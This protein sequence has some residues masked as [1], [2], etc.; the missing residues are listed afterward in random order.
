M[1]PAIFNLEDLRAR[2]PET[3][4]AL[5]TEHLSTLLAGAL[6]IGLSRPDAEEVVQDTFAAFLAGLDRFEGRSSVRTYLFGILY[7]KAS[8][9]RAKERREEGRD[10]IAAVVD[11]R[12]D[13]AGMWA[14]PPRGP[15]A[16][17]LDKE[18]RG[19]IERCSEGLSDDQRAAF[20]LK[21]VEG[22]EPAAICNVLGVSTTNLRV[23]LHRARLK[24]RECLERNWEKKAR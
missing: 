18:I 19:W 4:N 24:L 9:L 10:D 14:R 23:L 21:E 3:L 1:A 7:H 12:F 6:A 5:V 11:A 20:F 8:N 17:A 2:K 22:E 15:E 16:Q 13:A